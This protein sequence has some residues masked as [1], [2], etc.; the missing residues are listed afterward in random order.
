MPASGVCGLPWVVNGDTEFIKL[1]A[2]AEIAIPSLNTSAE[3]GRLTLPAYANRVSIY[4]IVGG[5]AA[6][7]ESAASREVIDEVYATAGA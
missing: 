5:D 2:G 7:E 3:Y 4:G 6:N 1:Y